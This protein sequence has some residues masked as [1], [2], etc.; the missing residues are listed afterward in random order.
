MTC[1][2]RDGVVDF[3]KFVSLFCD[4]YVYSHGLRGYIMEILKVLDPDEIY[5]K[6]RNIRVLAPKD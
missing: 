3:L 4:L 1:V 2:V 6:E 5:F